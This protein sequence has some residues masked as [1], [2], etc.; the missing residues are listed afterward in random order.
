MNGNIPTVNEQGK[1]VCV[2][3]SLSLSFM[4]FK[5]NI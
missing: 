3:A 1:K 2:Q 5:T 4:L